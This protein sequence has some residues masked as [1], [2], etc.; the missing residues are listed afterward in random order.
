MTIAIKQ[1]ATGNLYGR[2]PFEFALGIKFRNILENQYP[3]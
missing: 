3:L 2:F 1:D